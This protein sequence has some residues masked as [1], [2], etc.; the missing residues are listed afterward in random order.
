MV[1]TLACGFGIFRSARSWRPD[2]TAV[3]GAGFAAVTW[4]QRLL[5]VALAFA[6]SSL[7]LGVTT[8]IT[9][10]VASAPLLWVIP[11]ILY[12][13]TYVIVFSRRP[14]LRH[15]WMVKIQPFVLLPALF[16]MMRPGHWATFISDLAVFFV[17]AMVCHGELVRRRPAATNLTE[18][19]LLMSLGGVLG[20]VF[21]AVIAPVAFDGV[22][23]FAVAL[24]V[25][26]L[27][28]PGPFGGT[29]RERLLD[30]GLPALML[31]AMLSPWLFFDLNLQQF[32]SKGLLPCLILAAVLVF[33]F[34]DRPV[35]F[36][37]GMA[38]VLTITTL[39]P[40]L[41]VHDRQRSFFG[42]YSV[43]SDPAGET[44]GL[45]HGTTVHGAQSMD[46]AHWREPIAYYTRQGPLGQ[47]FA[48]LNAA[49][50]IH[51]VGLVGLGVGTVVCYRQPGQ[52]WT[53]YEIDPVV[54]RI[55]R[56]TRFFHYMSE[57]FDPD[58]METRLG[59]ARLVLVKE[60]SAAFDL[61]VLD[62]FSSDSVPVHLMT[63]EALAIYRDKLTDDG[64]ILVNISNRYLNL[65][66][67]LGRLIEDSGMHGRIQVHTIKGRDVVKGLSSVWVAIAK[68]EEALEPLRAAGAWRRLSAP[69]SVPV[70]TD[71]FSNILGV[72]QPMKDLPDLS[73]LWEN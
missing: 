48:V 12:L 29:A 64:V 22:Y 10:D 72:I 17:M 11:L 51:R 37:L 71:D 40:T 46:P 14:A 38:A 6:P 69:A 8:H 62:A 18:F 1:L 31:A 55:A 5:W 30:I 23:E 2:I 60:P 3:E 53:L 56:D 27:L 61:L 43:V 63:R 49:D 50:R 32:L 21:N 52:R 25:A 16:L 59:D 33:G 73:E 7:L 70:W 15:E 54:E 41:L 39:G 68:N 20:G 67:V 58:T 28:R 4:Q 44:Y 57:C 26:C 66:S 13:L 65:K 34:K 42:V 24:A 35:R 9:T 19:Y 45:R 36:G 47:A